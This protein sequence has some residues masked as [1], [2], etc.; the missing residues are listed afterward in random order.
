MASRINAAKKI[1]SKPKTEQYRLKALM[2]VR[3]QPSMTGQIMAT[4]PEGSLVH[5]LAIENGWLHLQDNT[6]ILYADGKF[7]DKA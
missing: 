3:D 6:Y 7:A 4:K 1:S 5:V 2:N